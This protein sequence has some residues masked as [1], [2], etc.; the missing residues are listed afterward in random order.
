MSR[1]R[2]SQGEG[3]FKAKGASTESILVTVVFDKFDD[4]N[5]LTH[6]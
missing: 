3:H 1:S 5:T 6:Y 4:I 2:L